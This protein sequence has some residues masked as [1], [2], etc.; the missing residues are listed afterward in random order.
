MTGETPNTAGVPGAPGEVPLFIDGPAYKRY[1][2]PSSIINPESLAAE[3]VT[4]FGT[5]AGL[6]KRYNHSQFLLRAE[7][8]VVGV[9]KK[10]EAAGEEAGLITKYA[11]NPSSELHHQALLLL[12]GGSF[13][14][15][16]E[17][18]D[19]MESL[20]VAKGQENLSLQA[21]HDQDK[22]NKLPLASLLRYYMEM[23]KVLSGRLPVNFDQ[24]NE[25]VLGT[26]YPSVVRSN[27]ATAVS[28]AIAGI[29]GIVGF[30]EKEYKEVSGGFP[31]VAPRAKR[32][33]GKTAEF[34]NRLFGTVSNPDDE[35]LVEIKPVIQNYI[36]E[37]ASMRGYLIHLMT[38]GE[39]AK[40]QQIYRKAKAMR[41]HVH[42]GEFYSQLSDMLLQYSE[43]HPDFTQ[44]HTQNDLAELYSPNGT[45]FDD[46]TPTMEDF[47]QQVAG[48]I[49]IKPRDVY[50]F[51]FDQE[52]LDTIEWGEV[53]A[54]QSANLTFN[55]Q[56]S[57][58]LS[59]VFY[60]EGEIEQAKVILGMY[61]KTGI[62]DWNFIEDPQD[63]EMQQYSNAVKIVIGQILANVRNRLSDQ[64]QKKRADNNPAPPS[65][66][67]PTKGDTV[68]EVPVEKTEDTE[69]GGQAIYKRPKAKASKAGD[70]AGSTP[71][72]EME[73]E[74]K[75]TIV[76]P[77]GEIFED[78]LSP[79]SPEDQRRARAGIVE[80]NNRGVAGI[81]LIETAK[82]ERLWSLRIGKGIRV[83]LREA[84]VE[85]GLSKYEII[86]ARR[87]GDIYK[88]NK[89]II[90]ET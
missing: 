2:A 36:G 15:V 34:H 55:S 71:H 4:L 65:I 33:I 32:L 83:L 62:F 38:L 1:D 48:I 49:S 9:V 78:L 31:L 66:N 90:R 80:A 23:R 42:H 72:A 45:V 11:T 52:M 39:L 56:K 12:V 26:Q 64:R 54:P 70:T 84:G 81:K 21:I 57:M 79:L 17:L 25:S 22:R 28:L 6:K 75:R 89:R 27:L 37:T 77:E 68:Y 87:R 73:Q 86:D 76:I 18:S 29:N 20:F 8:P 5:F 3:K 19:R 59:V 43:I 7:A 41:G 13:L 47:R 53:T 67:S 61:P 63:P 69:N 74:V 51:S 35:E 58:A 85:D 44:L 30:G 88:A 82:Y 10:W 16:R 50:E 14:H 24:D 40:V 46:S 60:Y